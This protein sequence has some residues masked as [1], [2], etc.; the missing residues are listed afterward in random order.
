MSLS[1]HLA[2]P[3]PNP[4]SIP[5]AAS[6]TCGRIAIPFAPLLRRT[7]AP[8]PKHYKKRGQW[9]CITPGTVSSTSRIAIVAKAHSA[10]V[11]PAAANARTPALV[12][13][14]GQDAKTTRVLLP[15]TIS[16]PKNTQCYMREVRATCNE[17]AKHAEKRTNSIVASTPF[18]TFLLGSQSQGFVCACC[19]FF[20]RDAPSMLSHL[21]LPVETRPMI[22]TTD[23]T[24]M[25]YVPSEYPDHLKQ[26]FLECDRRP[27]NPPYHLLP[28]LNG[29]VLRQRLLAWQ[30]Q[31]EKC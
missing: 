28:K 8:H 31:C 29:D 20:T 22:K 17:Y 23:A 26:Y 6:V 24:F 21:Q 9:F 16:W 15:V 12:D 11:T 2:A 13:I 25:P 30:S 1:P 10:T 7:V 14:R 3:P 27:S 4:P 5:T 18:D 19:G